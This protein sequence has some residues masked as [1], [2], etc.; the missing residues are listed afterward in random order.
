[1]PKHFRPSLDFLYQIS[2]EFYQNGF[3]IS[4]LRLSF[5]ELF[6]GIGIRSEILVTV[7]ISGT[8]LIIW[9]PSTNY[10]FCADHCEFL[11][12]WLGLLSRECLNTHIKMKRKVL[13]FSV[14][15]EPP[16][17]E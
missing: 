15:S 13:L 11:L 5:N 16:M 2:N 3:L 9:I 4:G 7:C 17:V 6:I 14:G 12:V 10:E 8:Q 1:M